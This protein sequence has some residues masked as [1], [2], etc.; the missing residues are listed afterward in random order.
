M[1]FHDIATTLQGEI[2]CGDDRSI[3]G[4]STDT[5]T[6]QPGDL[7]V[8]LVGAN[9]DGHQFIEQAF[10]KGA[11]ACLS[12]RR[13]V[14]G[15]HVI[16]VK[17][18]LE[19]L[20][21]LAAKQRENAG[22]PVIAVTG[23][24]GKTSTRDMIAAVVSQQYRTLQTSGNLNNHIGLP[25]T[26]LKYQNEEAMVLEMGMNHLGEISRLSQ[27]AR[28]DIAVITNVGTAH[29][30]LVGSRENILRAKLEITDGLQPGG[31]LLVNTDN[32]L[33]A[34]F[35]STF[36]QTAHAY[37]LVTYGIQGTPMIHAEDVQLAEDHSCF[38]CEGIRFEVPVP[39][40][41]FVLNALAA[42]GVARCLAI[43][44]RKAQEALAAFRLTA[45]R[46]DIFETKRG[47]KIID[48]SYNAN[49]DSMLS[50]LRVL[51]RYPNRKIAV[52]GDMLELGDYQEQLHMQTGEAVDEAGV[53][54]L[55]AVGKASRQ[56]VD[57]AKQTKQK[58]WFSAN[59]QALDF[60][61][62]VLK[63]G[64]VVLIKA[65]NSMHFN[66]IVDGLKEMESNETK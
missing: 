44:L 46:M 51:A 59:A 26:I 32:D 10:A 40:E 53:D 1:N 11:A 9:F 35:A 58:L 14:P 50:S 13:E 41:H 66:E 25:L 61:R 65:S 8:P 54:L 5:R 16:L 18:T 34:K 30:G 33:L 49:L 47:I 43:S 28:P 45:K 2:L 62:H 7:Y 37:R 31:V 63:A 4:I 36:D 19:A 17:D 20:Q 56:I 6:L 15:S 21:R 22:V 52:L 12:D 55:V 60:L 48:G 39:G 64:D 24:V 3:N 42:I 57:G 29:I 38:T 27:I 23:S